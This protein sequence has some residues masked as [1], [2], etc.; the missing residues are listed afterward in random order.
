MPRHLL[1]LMTN[2]YTK[3]KTKTK[4]KPKPKP[5][6]KIYHPYHP[7]ELH[8]CR[9]DLQTERAEREDFSRRWEEERRQLQEQIQAH[10][11]PTPTPLNPA[12]TLL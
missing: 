9:E 5:K 7:Q 2:H 11:I 4:P 6:P 8:Q 10:L 3:T 1:R 12:R